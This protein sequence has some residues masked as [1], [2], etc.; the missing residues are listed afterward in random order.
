MSIH[1]TAAVVVTSAALVLGLTA[2]ATVQSA[3]SSIVRAPARCVDQTVQIYFESYSAEITK[4]G[5]AV[6][7]LAANDAKACHVTSIDVLGLAD[8]VGAADANLALSK[9]RAAAVTQALA[10]TGLPA[11]EFKV[12][13]AGDA[14]AVTAKG[15]PRLLRRRVD[16]LLHLSAK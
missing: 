12:T 2:C 16:V 14:G 11:G 6:L 9:Q 10:S 15:D 7:K 3:R 8:S 5:L 1:K 13:A 4:E